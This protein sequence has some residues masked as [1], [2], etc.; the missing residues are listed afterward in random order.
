MCLQLF[1]TPNDV[2]RLSR[3]GGTQTFGEK[4]CHPE[5]IRFAQGKLRAGSGSP[6]AQILRCAQDDRQDTAHVLSREALSPNVWRGRAPLDKPAKQRLI[7]LL[8]IYLYR[9]DEAA[10]FREQH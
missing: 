7:Y 5:P 6:D 2:E 10:C 9:I 1:P 8:L 3:G 4:A